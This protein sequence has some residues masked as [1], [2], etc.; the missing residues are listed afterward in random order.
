MIVLNKDNSKNSDNNKIYIYRLL[1]LYSV[2]I[3]WYQ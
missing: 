1:V 3:I 2:V